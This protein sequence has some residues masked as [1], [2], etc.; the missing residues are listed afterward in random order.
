MIF[1]QGFATQGIVTEVVD[2]ESFFIQQSSSEQQ[3]NN[4][5]EQLGVYCESGQAQNPPQLALGDYILA[6]FSEDRAWYRA[7][8]TGKF[9]LISSSNSS[10]GFADSVAL[11]LIVIFTRTSQHQN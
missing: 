8:I 1:N 10:K 5:M 2:P 4:L 6:R 3:L 7:K 11:V 9:C